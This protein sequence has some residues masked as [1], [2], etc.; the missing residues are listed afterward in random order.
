MCVCKWIIIISLT[1]HKVLL[2]RAKD[3]IGND[4]FLRCAGCDSERTVLEGK[5]V[6]SEFNIQGPKRLLKQILT[7]KLFLY[8]PG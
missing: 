8:R 6:N 1:S 5:A 7:V 3:Q 4:Y 2:E